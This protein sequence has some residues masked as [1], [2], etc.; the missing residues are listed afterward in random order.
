MK[1]DGI[2]LLI[3]ND[4]ELYNHKDNCFIRTCQERK[5]KI[6]FYCC[7]KNYLGCPQGLK[8]RHL[9]YI[10]YSIYVLRTEIE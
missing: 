8:E 4:V 2:P 3:Y 9:A 1:Y 10:P 6:L 7:S 5:V